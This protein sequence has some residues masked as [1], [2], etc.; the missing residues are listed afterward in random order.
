MAQKFSLKSA[1]QVRTSVTM[2]QQK[3]I[4][5]LYEQ[6][7]QDVT[8]QVSVMGN[9]NIK[10]Q[11]LIL[12][13]RDIKTRIQQINDDIQ[14]GI[15][16]NMKIVSNAV[17]VDTR[18][19]LKQMGF[20]D[21]DI[22][23]AF[24]HVPDQIVRNIITGNVYQEGWTLSG[25]I[26]GYNKDIQDG[27]NHIISINT[28]QG[29]SAYEIAKDI[30]SY[31]EPGARKVSRT[32]SSWRY[33]T[34]NDGQTGKANAVG[35]KIKDK[36]YFG[37][38]DYNAQRLARTLVSHA[39]QQSFETVNKN[40]PFVTG[41][42]WNTS[43]FHGRVCIICQERATQ[44]NYG[45]GRGVYPK[46]KLPLDHPNGMCTFEAVIPD[47]MSTIADKIGKWYQAP[48]GTYPDIDRYAMDFVI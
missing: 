33:A 16:R 17:V 35:E 9:E 23:N 24:M 41:Y 29:K 47:S 15:I 44:N 6:L 43:S 21:S 32:I 2:A 18:T 7:Y 30:E 10:K 42:K 26:W 46:D 28:A 40:D 25:T 39:Y 45:L 1:E 20:K 38:V 48:L 27:L 4:K 19:F 37:R 34:V 31:V 3:E 11:N 36:F 22:N 8:K 14:N 5:K 12:L 13:Q